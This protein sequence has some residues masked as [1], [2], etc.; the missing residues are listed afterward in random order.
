MRTLPFWITAVS[1][2][3]LLTVPPAPAFDFVTY[4]YDDAGRVVSVDYA[5]GKFIDY[6]Y[7]P[8][9][10]LLFRT[11][12]TAMMGN[13]FPDA[14]VDLKD[15]IVALQIACRI[16]PPDSISIRCDANADGMIGLAEALYVLH[17]VSGL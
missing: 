10:N 9:G 15:A 17:A 6:S 16:H 13:V 4:T 14:A 8:A 12:G 2:A 7:D 5:N 3:V 11:T 1:L